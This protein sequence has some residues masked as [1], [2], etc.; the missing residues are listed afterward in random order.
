MQYL[1]D[2]ETLVGNALADGL[3]L[4]LH[5][6]KMALQVLNQNEELIDSV[7]L[8]GRTWDET[9][10]SMKRI[11][12]NSGIDI[13]KI[14]NE[15]HFEIPF[16]PLADGASFDI[17]E[18][19]Y[20]KENAIYRHNSEIILHEVITEYPNASPIRVWPHHFDTGTFI[21]LDSNE[22]SGVSKSIGLGWAIPDTMVQEPYYYLSFWSAETDKILESLN[23]LP[24]GKWLM[25]KWNGAVLQHSDILQL[26][27]AEKQYN[28]V[29]SF[30]ESGI[31]I[32]YQYLSK[33]A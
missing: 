28:L 32:L 31:S 6:S 24:A 16:H 2:N 3:H 7:E 15:L 12:Q 4:G 25:P 8:N 18:L 20:F 11:L 29:K 9:F 13:L 27:S 14:N 10:D 17:R 21:P 19:K 22:S 1:P 23:P 30:F 5:L 26:L 33:D